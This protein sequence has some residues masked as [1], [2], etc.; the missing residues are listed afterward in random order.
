[1]GKRA[2]GGQVLKRSTGDALSFFPGA[3]SLELGGSRIFFE[4]AEGFVV[5]TWDWRAF[6]CFGFAYFVLSHSMVDQWGKRGKTLGGL[7]SDLRGLSSFDLLELLRAGKQAG[8]CC[9]VV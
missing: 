3:L 1:M 7:R 4:T 6:S 2:A 8:C 5:S 9:E